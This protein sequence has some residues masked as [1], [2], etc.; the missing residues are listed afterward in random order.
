MKK[1]GPHC[2]I[3]PRAEIGE[4]VII[5]QGVIIDGPVKIGNNV[6]IGAY[7]TISGH[8]SIGDGNRISPYV[9]LGAPPQ[10]IKYDESIPSYVEI[11]NN[12]IIREYVSIHRATGEGTVTKLGDNCM[13]M[14]YAHLGHN[15]EVGNHV[16]M[17]NSVQLAGHTIV[18]DRV[19]ISGLTGTHQFARIGK[20]AMI[21]GMSRINQDALPFMITNGNPP[22]VH[23]PNVVGLRRNGLSRE[24]INQLRVLYKMLCRSKLP[25]PK[26]LECIA[27]EFDPTPEV[28]YVLDFIEKSKRG[29]IR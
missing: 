5:G 24:A 21:G 3:D 2:I 6:Q 25:M 10:D 17:A 29:V 26:A 18:E 23:G 4:D 20:M 8:V 16:I 1:I 13:L 11:G 19:V 14:S 15:C 7:C 12:N 28:Q 27:Q 9:T 22:T